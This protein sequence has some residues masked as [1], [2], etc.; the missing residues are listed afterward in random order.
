MERGREGER[1]RGQLLAE[2]VMHEEGAGGRTF[3][4]CTVHLTSNTLRP[5]LAHRGRGAHVH[6]H[7]R[8]AV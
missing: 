7:R 3:F 5:E 8:T 1:G 2:N 4:K 6:R